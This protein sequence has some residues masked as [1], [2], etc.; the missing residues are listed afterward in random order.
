E[1]QRGALRAARGLHRRLV[2]HLQ[3][4]RG[5][6]M[7]KVGGGWWRLGLI[8]VAGCTGSSSKRLYDPAHDL[9]PMFHDVQIA[10]V[11]PDSKTF[12]D[13]RPRY[14]LAT[15]VS[16]YNSSKG[17]EGFNLRGFVERHFDLPKPVGGE[18]R[19]DTTQTLD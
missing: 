9:G 6:R 14:P 2:D 12:V 7:V 16:M 18:F 3:M 13:A 4:R 19:S 17:A 1:G 15:I 8:V 10:G 5:A 11:F